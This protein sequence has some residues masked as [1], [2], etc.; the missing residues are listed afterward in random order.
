MAHGPAINANEPG[1]IVESPARTV[2]RAWSACAATNLYGVVRRTT[3]STDLSASSCVAPSVANTASTSPTAPITVRST[4]RDTNGANPCATNART[5]A[6]TSFAVDAGSITTI[7]VPPAAR[8]ERTKP[9]RNAKHPGRGPGR[10]RGTAYAVRSGT[11]GRGPGEFPG[12]RKEP[13]EPITTRH[14]R[15]MVTTTRRHV[16][17]VL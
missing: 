5:T 10:L 11:V 3:R 2:E 9:G 4:P 16:K 12:A 14:D 15:C 1:P 8:A 7:T 17:R 13:T 6:S